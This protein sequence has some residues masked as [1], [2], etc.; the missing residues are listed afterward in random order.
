[1]NYTIPA[2]YPPAYM[3]GWT[4]FLD[5][6]GK[7]EQEVRFAIP[8]MPILGAKTTSRLIQDVYRAIVDEATAADFYTRLLQQA[9]NP[10]HKDFI[11]HARN[12]ELHHL[13][14]FTRLYVHLTGQQPRYSITPV[15]FESF[16]EGVLKAFQDELE[17]AEF[18]RDIMLSVT[19]PMIRDT[20]LYAMTDEMEHATRFSF[21]YQQTG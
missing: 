20:F 9:A 1:M 7:R 12:D 2:G 3:Y 21:I 6:P 11:T 4:A 10:L 14:A 15:R 17:A 19:D 18:Y 16:R 8:M 13:R 5:H